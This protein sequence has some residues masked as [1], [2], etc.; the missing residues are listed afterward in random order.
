LTL[1]ARL[2]D[3][4]HMM[5]RHLSKVREAW[6][7]VPGRKPS[8]ALTGCGDGDGKA[9][10]VTKQTV[11]EGKKNNFTRF[12]NIFTC[13]K[14]AEMLLLHHLLRKPDNVRF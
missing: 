6:L 11:T 12:R 4:C 14:S 3:R 2:F 1:V 10:P 13:R 8:G 7:P 5:V 9:L